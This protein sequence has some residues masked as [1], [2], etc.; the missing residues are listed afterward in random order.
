M[1]SIALLFFALLPSPSFAGVSEDFEQGSGGLKAEWLDT[2]GQSLIFL[3]MC[4]LVIWVLQSSLKQLAKAN[5]GD[6]YSIFSLIAR[7]VFLC[8]LV[9]LTLT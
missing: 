5:D 6:G 4:V 1:K 7:S 9:I 3:A 8:V 2:V